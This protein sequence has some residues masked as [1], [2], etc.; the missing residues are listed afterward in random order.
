MKNE[1]CASEIVPV[2]DGTETATPKE[3]R[4]E[5]THEMDPQH[6]GQIMHKQTGHPC[7]Q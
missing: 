2:L 4:T 5:A 3:H 6:D 1:H 7:S